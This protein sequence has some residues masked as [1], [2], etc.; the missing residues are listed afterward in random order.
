MRVAYFNV[1]IKVDIEAKE[2]DEEAASRPAK[3]E[4]AWICFHAEEEILDFSIS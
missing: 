3:G 4:D 2:K 1:S